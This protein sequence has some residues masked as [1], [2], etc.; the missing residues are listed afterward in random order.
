MKQRLLITL[1]LIIIAAVVV[2]KTS[3]DGNNHP[4]NKGK[5]IEAQ[6]AQVSG[7]GNTEERDRPDEAFAQEFEMTKDDKLGYPPTMR[8]VE[9]YDE[10]KDQLS[11]QI[12]LR[13]AIPG[14]EWIERGP[15]NVGGRTRALM[16]DPNDNTA[17]K[18]WA[19]AVGG[20]L[21]YN[22]D[23]TNPASTW[24]QETD[25]MT[26]LAIST[27]THDP[28]DTQ[29]FYVGTGLGYTGRIRGAGI[30]K[31]TDGGNTWA[32]LASTDIPAFNFV[33]KMAVTAQGTVLAT[34]TSGLHRS[35]DDGTSWTVVQSG[36]FGDIEIASD[37]TIY[38]TQGVNSTGQVFKSTDD[39]VTWLNV[40]PVSGGART[41]IA[42]APSNP[43]V[44]YVVADG[45]SGANDVQYFMK[46]TDAGATWENI[47]IPLYTNHASG[48]CE[49]TTQHYTRGQAFFNLII[50]VHPENEDIVF[51]GGIDIMRSLDGGNSWGT[52]TYWNDDCDE[53]A[54]ADQHELIFRPGY[55]N[56]LVAANDGGVDYSADAGNA[57]D[58]DFERRVRGY[59]TVTFYY[60]A[61]ANEIGS[62]NIMAG[63]Q[64]NGTLRLSEPG[65][66]SSSEV[67][68]GDGA[69]CFIDP[70]DPN[71]QIMSVTNNNYFLTT[72]GLTPTATIAS[73]NTGRFIN[74]ADMDWEEGVLYTGS[75][76]DQLGV[77]TG[78]PNSPSFSEVSLNLGG[79]QISAVKVSPYTTNRIFVGVSNSGG[80]RIYRIDNASGG[81]PLVFDITGNLDGARGSFLKSIDIG[82]SDDQLLVTFSN[83]GAA[84]VYETQNAGS[85][86][87]NKE[88]NLPDIPVRWG[89]YN[90]NDRRQ[91]LIA[92]DLGVWS[93]NDITAA[94]PGWEAT[95]SGLA[96]VRTDHLL[97]RPAD[98]TII[99]ATFGRGVFTSNVFATTVKADF[100]AKQVVGYVGMPV[101]FE[102]ASLL[103]GD[104]WSWDF[105]DGGSSSNQNPSHTYQAA[106]TYDVA[107]SIANDQ[108]TE[109]KT[110]YVTILPAITPPYLAADGGDFE[111]NPG[112][113]T[114]RAVLNNTNLWERGTPGNALSTLA[115]GS[116]AWKTKL[117]SDIGD[118]GFDHQSA[119]YTPSFDLSDLNKDYTTSFKL[120]IETAFCNLP[121]AMKMEYSL[122]GGL[123]WSTLGSSRGSLGDVNWYNRGPDQSCLI[124]GSIFKDQI[125]W[126]Q[127]VNGATTD[128]NIETR[129][130]LDHLAG[131]SNVSFRFLVGVI[132]GGSSAGSY[133][134]DG[135]M[136][137]DFEI[138]ATAP[139]ADF[140]A[141]QTLSFEGANVKF[142]HASNGGDTFLWNFGDGNTSTDKNPTHSYANAGSYTVSLDV[143]TNGQTSTI[144]KTDYISVIPSRGVPYEL[145]DGGDFESNTT[146]FAAVNEAGTPFELGTSVVAGKDGTASGSNAWV[147]DLTSSAY[148]DDSRAQLV[149]PLFS[150]TDQAKVYTLEFKA[151][152]KFENQWDGFIVNYTID[153]G[154]TW[155]KLNNNIET[156]WYNTTSD[157]L[158]VFGASVPMFSGDTEG[159]YV[160]YS[161]DVTFLFSH[162]VAFQIDFRTDAN[163]TDVGMAVDDF[164]ILLTD[165]EAFSVD[166]DIQ[167]GSGCSGQQVVFTST[168][169]GAIS[170]YEWDFG[171]NANPATATGVGPHTVTY[172]STG[173][174]TV[175]LEATSVFGQNATE[176]KTDVINTSASHTPSFVEEDNGDRDIARLVASDG[177]TYQWNLDGNP[178]ANATSQI[179]LATERGNYTVDVTVNGCT[180]RTSQQNIVTSTEQ[181][182]RFQES[183]TLYPNPTQ[184]II[185]VKVSNAELGE[186]KIAFHS[187]TGATILTKTVQKSTFDAEYQFSL[188]NVEAGTYLVEIQSSEGRGVKRIF[189]Q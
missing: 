114:S 178:I 26:N 4:I 106:G 64:D 10:L 149:S 98:E 42:T 89:I 128:I 117:D 144:S 135:F 54:H 22:N 74:P 3:S 184:D 140:F 24:I 118:L 62:N 20:G 173:A 92:T 47:T 127:K 32:H 90:P 13:S 36:R 102:D 65:I 147:T 29:V 115:S 137:D 179:L 2:V 45:G 125:G 25:I 133:S 169:T 18:L 94:N 113:F 161:T 11:S 67:F 57:A 71:I 58:P 1:S 164:Q 182:Q 180:V 132:D 174:S 23:I 100:K 79:N 131:N 17:K 111:T 136:I 141:D 16:F 14:V 27:I 48:N 153:N 151:K 44:V 123:A 130:R 9:A 97:Y 12:G 69:F 150:F 28:T 76:T 152:Y 138:L 72:N 77:A 107:L 159:E 183:I 93:T 19:G 129:A 68:G 66:G 162:N 176:T 33:Q 109:T 158:S 81:A 110:G 120:S 112:H 75:G 70:N 166:F 142:N 60:A 31:S 105:G 82:A 41:E 38:S 165:A 37:G 30:W 101:Q 56:T 188:A 103:P 177:D 35:T 49:L 96:S 55:P 189:K 126:T 63:A 187:L 171:A 59:N 146:D 170:S 186:L 21:W 148:V 85:N 73:S 167:T 163:T 155:T 157:P 172:S 143:T 124:H 116:N 7:M 91:V 134:A 83:F 175:S 39:G 8:L 122:D 87:I 181:D 99:A 52:V 80:G 156:G 51:A 119:L 168:A 6:K 53:L 185:N 15:N 78:V 43:D 139:G 108:D 95:N 84:S 61:S 5:I 50:A 145:A 121:I 34:T 154:Q 40:T 104:Q 88:D 46:S 86:W 160:T